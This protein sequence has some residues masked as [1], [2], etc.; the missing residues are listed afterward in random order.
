MRFLL[1]I[2]VMAFSFA[3]AAAELQPDDKARADKEQ[4]I[5]II[6]GHKFFSLRD[7]RH[8]SGPKKPMPLT[9][10]KEPRPPTIMSHERIPA[11]QA[12][13]ENATGRQAGETIN[14][15]SLGAPF[16]VK[17]GTPATDEIKLPQDIS[18]KANTANPSENKS[19]T[20]NSPVLDI[21]A[22]DENSR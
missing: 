9:T 6:N 1:V 4:K 15:K 18:G 3:V 8:F 11:V 2:A 21:F 17:S 16:F 12:P 20:V 13:A 22:P 5:T 7:A 19:A 10:K 14:P